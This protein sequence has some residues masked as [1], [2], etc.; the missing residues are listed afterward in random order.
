LFFRSKNTSDGY[1]SWC[2]IC[3][4]EGN[5]KSREKQN[6]TIE[7]RAKVFL[8][9]AR[10]SALKRN[11]EFSLGVSD[12]VGCWIAQKGFCAYSGRRM[13]LRAGSLATVSIERIDSGVGYT[14]DNVVLVCQAINRMKS[15]F[16]LSEFFELCRDVAQFIGDDEGDLAVGAYK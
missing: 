7:G 8:R 4:L 6:S 2:K 9:N 14:P 5:E 15:D 16:T 13:T 3:C 11:Q 12:I 1:H 10:N